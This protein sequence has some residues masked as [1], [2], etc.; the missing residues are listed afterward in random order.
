MDGREYK[1]I[2][3]ARVIIAKPAHPLSYFAVVLS[4]MTS[5]LKDFDMPAT[6]ALLE[7]ARADIEQEL[8]RDPDKVGAEEA[9]KSRR[10]NRR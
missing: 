2:G 1:A 4:Q 9:R 3:G 6:A 8:A 5:T 10:E 7:R